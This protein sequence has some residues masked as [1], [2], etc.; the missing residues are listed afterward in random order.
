MT[1]PSIGLGLFVLLTQTAMTNTPTTETIVDNGVGP[2]IIAEFQKELGTYGFEQK[3]QDGGHPQFSLSP[4]GTTI[5]SRRERTVVTVSI[6]LLKATRL[7]RRRHFIMVIEKARTLLDAPSVTSQPGDAKPTT[8]IE[9]VAPAVKTPAPLPPPGANNQTLPL[10][11]RKPVDLG[12]AT[13]LSYNAGD[14]GF[15][16]HAAL[17]GQW[18]AQP[19]IALFTRILWPL[20]DSTQITPSQ[21]ARM[22][23]FGWDI[24]A[25]YLHRNGLLRPFVSIA[26][27]GRLLLIDAKLNPRAAVTRIGVNAN[28]TAGVRMELTERASLFLSLE[29]G[30][31][32]T[33]GSDGSTPEPVRGLS[34]LSLASSIGILFLR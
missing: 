17:I 24:G 11:P 4:D 5:T 9:P 32:S 12:A 13:R 22:W 19:H 2:L 34:G 31:D 1:L 8:V 33:I 16:S 18:Y 23:T 14:I 3:T 26:A 28:S 27:G 10:T 25:T 30:H 29:V 21:V 15:T 6:D 7:E 20:Q